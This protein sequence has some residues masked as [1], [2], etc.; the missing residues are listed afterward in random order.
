[1]ETWLRDGAVCIQGITSG[2]VHF[3]ARVPCEGTQN[4]VHGMAFTAPV[5]GHR[6]LCFSVISHEIPFKWCLLSDLDAGC[7]YSPGVA[8]QIVDRPCPSLPL[9]NISRFLAQSFAQFLHDL[10]C[11]FSEFTQILSI[12][13]NFV[14]C[15]FGSIRIHPEASAAVGKGASDTQNFAH[16]TMIFIHAPP[17]GGASYEMVCFSEEHFLGECFWEE[18]FWEE[19]KEVCMTS[20]I[21]AI[22]TLTGPMFWF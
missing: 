1:M 19:L 9:P 7:H 13:P 11:I 18:L 14:K 17:L 12:L 21:T 10:L 3:S 16:F 5:F 4:C 15:S 6:A 2:I 22:R 8:L 20:V